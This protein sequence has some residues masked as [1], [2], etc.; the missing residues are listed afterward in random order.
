MQ[1]YV[2][3]KIY[4]DYHGDFNEF[5]A[6]EIAYVLMYITHFTSKFALLEVEMKVVINIVFDCAKNVKAGNFN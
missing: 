2:F 3:F 4:E 6:E 5:C 1:Y